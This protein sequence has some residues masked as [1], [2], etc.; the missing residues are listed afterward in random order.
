[1]KR[2]IKFR[3]WIPEVSDGEITLPGYMELNP[4]WQDV[5]AIRTQTNAVPDR[6]GFEHVSDQ[7]SSLNKICE[8]YENVLMQFIGLTD[9]NGVE[10]YEGDIRPWCNEAFGR[11][12]PVWLSLLDALGDWFGRAYFSVGNGDL[13]ADFGFLCAERAGRELAS[14][15]RLDATY[16]SLAE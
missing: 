8:N 2:E 13:D 16:R 7:I 10:I 14:C 3:A 12:F 15:L 9:K 4:R 11:D 1:M 6:F 5:R